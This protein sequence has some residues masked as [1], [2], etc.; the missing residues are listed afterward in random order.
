MNFEALVYNGGVGGVIGF[1]VGVGV[2]IVLWV[3]TALQDAVKH[4]P[5]APFFPD[6]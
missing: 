5:S 2:M 1:G 3:T 4:L 6:D